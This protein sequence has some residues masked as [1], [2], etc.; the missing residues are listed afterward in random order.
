MKNRRLIIV[1]IILALSISNTNI[2]VFGVDNTAESISEENTIEQELY[3]KTEMP[4]DGNSYT[5]GEVG[6]YLAGNMG[7]V[8]VLYSQRRFTQPYNGHAF[9]AE[10]ANNFMD[11]LT[12]L[13]TKARVVGEDNLK[14]GP[15]RVL[16]FSDGSYVFIQD[17]Y[18]NTARNTLNAAFDNESG[19]YRYMTADGEPMLLEVPKDQYDDV[20][21]MMK[22]KIEAGKVAGIT[23]PEE[24]ENIIKPGYF[25]YEQAKNIA[26]AGNVDSL[27]YDAAN[28]AVVASYAFGISFVMEFT[29]NKFSGKAWDEALK[30]SFGNSLKTGGAVFGIHVI[31]SQICKTEI[32]SALSPVT[33]RVSAAL[34]PKVG[35]LLL[36]SSGGYVEGMSESAIASGTSKLIQENIVVATVTI[37]VLSVGDAR[38]LLS[39][40]ISAKQFAANIAQTTV[41]VTGGVVGLNVGRVIGTAVSHGVGTAVGQFAGGAIGYVVAD[42]GGKTVIKEIY[43]SDAEE[44]CEIITEEFQKMSE[45]YIISQEEADVITGMIQDRLDGETLKEMYAS[46]D[47][48]DF[49]KK[50]MTPLFDNTVA[51]REK[52]KMPTVE[53]ARHEFKKELEGVI[54]IH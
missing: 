4:Q 28:G 19:M 2:A 48:T 7:T 22:E 5:T 13:N 6:G 26:K 39:K 15:D 25:T 53:E 43:K 52:I 24:A 3:G 46:T 54:Y 34:G 35:E 44:M 40:R 17:K 20:L 36:K 33:D 27:K 45:D 32:P 23:N 21:L 51:K 49:A 50:L 10:R 31:S 16:E 37:A 41:G 29:A 38:E 12:N 9:A 47:R 1:C 42:I 14:N 30:N 8:N 18:Y 11:N